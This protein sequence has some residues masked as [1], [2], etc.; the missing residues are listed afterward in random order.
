MELL[1]Q[2]I[3]LEKV[4]TSMTI[5]S[6]SMILLAL[7]V[8]V[9]KRQGAP[10][11]QLRGTV[12]NDILKEYIA[13]G[14]YIYPPRS[15]MRIVTDLFSWAKEHPPKWN[16]ISISGYHMREAGATAAQELGFTL[17]H[18]RAYIDAALEAGLAVADVVPHKISVGVSHRGAHHKPVGAKFESISIAVAI[19]DA[20]ATCVAF[21]ESIERAVAIAVHVA[22]GE[23]IG[24]PVSISQR[25]P[26]LVAI[27]LAILVTIL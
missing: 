17:A 14:T 10:I 19:A 7:Y 22:I 24:Q 9:A 12:Q 26:V 2:G 3:S 16:V 21:H 20:M 13:R 8:A 5:N 15:S 6:T 27:D 23:S 1:F 25:Q 18:A 11:D 4:S